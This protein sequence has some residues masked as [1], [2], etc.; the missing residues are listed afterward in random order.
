MGRLIA[1][2]LLGLIVSSMSSLAFGA[3]QLPAAAASKESNKSL[4]NKFPEGEGKEIVLS[5]CVQ[6]H[7]LGE[8]ISHRMDAKG[9]QKSILDMVARGT[10]LL[11]GESE[12]LVQYLAANF[13]PLININKA[14]ATELASL[15]SMDK[16]LA[17]AIVRYREKN[18]PFKQ[19]QDISRV[20]GASP[21]ILEKIKDRISTGS[22]SNTGKKK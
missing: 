13:G 16:A 20:E 5:A 14:T 4:A 21:E 17:E 6:C 9:W 18:G 1:I 19:I 12:T 8:I 15:P 7:G 3:G 22:L 11:P 2:A 10:Q